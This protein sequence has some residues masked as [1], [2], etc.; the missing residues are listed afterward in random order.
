MLKYLPI[1]LASI[2]SICVGYLFSPEPVAFLMFSATVLV[3]VA[4]ALL[5]RLSWSNKLYARLKEGSTD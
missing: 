2:V 3:T 1:A 5:I 4:L